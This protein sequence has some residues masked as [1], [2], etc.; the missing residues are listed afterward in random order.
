MTLIEIDEKAF[1]NKKDRTLLTHSDSAFLFD[2][3][4]L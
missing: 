4:T 2:C 1:K 3:S